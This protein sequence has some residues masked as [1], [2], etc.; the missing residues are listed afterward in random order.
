MIDAIFPGEAWIEMLKEKLNGDEKYAQIARNWEGDLLFLIEPDEL[1]SEPLVI[2]LDLWHGKCRSAAILEE[3]GD[4]EPTFGLKGPYQNFVKVLT[5]EWQTMQALLTRKLKLEGNMAYMVR[6]V[7]T[8][9]EFV[10]CCQE[11]TTTYL[12]APGEDTHATHTQS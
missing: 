7:P 9:L 3:Q 11:I 1:L 5:G 12:G 6:N 2:Y 4:L 10:R 8:V